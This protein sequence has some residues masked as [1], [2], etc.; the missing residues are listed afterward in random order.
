MCNH[1][2]T[3]ISE[4]GYGIAIL[5]D[6]KYGISVNGSTL[7]LTLHKGGCNPDTRGDAGVHSFTYSFLPHEGGF[8]ADTTIRQGYLLNCPMLVSEG[9]K[10][11]QKLLSVDKSNI[12][13][14]AIKPCE[15]SEKAFIVRL[16]E[17]E[18]TYTHVT[19]SADRKIS[20]MK[21]CDMLENEQEDTDSHLS[22]RPFEIKTLKLSY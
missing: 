13:V 11:V 7:A 16:Y 1:K 14:E 18:G 3:D 21:I 15:E 19:L 10:A 12:V 5:N 2:Y 20:G 17:A 8:A 4:P 9:S 22:F 6:C